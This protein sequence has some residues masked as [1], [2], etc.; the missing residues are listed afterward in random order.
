MGGISYGGRQATMLAASDPDLVDGLLVLSYPLHPPGKPEQLR[1]SHLCKI[2][3]PALFVSGVKDP[4]GSPAELSA[5]IAQ[6]AASA[7]LISIEGVGHDLGFNRRS[8]AHADLPDTIVRA[9]EE[10]F[11][12]IQICKTNQ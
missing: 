1:T 9:F 6:I 11:L 2:R 4:F 5:A 8:R 3:K 7:S 10:S 12:Q